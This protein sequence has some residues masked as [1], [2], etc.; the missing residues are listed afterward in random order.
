LNYFVRGLQLYLFCR[1]SFHG[2]FTE[3]L[4]VFAASFFLF[5]SQF[6]AA[7]RQLLFH[8]AARLAK[9]GKITRLRSGTDVFKN[10]Y[11][12]RCYE[13]EQGE[14]KGWYIGFEFHWRYKFWTKLSP[15]EFI[16]NSF[17]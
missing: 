9:E 11:T 1:K 5:Q 10:R 8:L 2:K 14:G 3:K 12:G 4:L 17:I 16:S 6:G 15:F 7:W 13:N